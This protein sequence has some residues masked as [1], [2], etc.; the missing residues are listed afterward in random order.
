MKEKF[1]RSNSTWEKDGVAK[2]VG[3]IEKRIIH[4][5]VRR[6]KDV[7]NSVMNRV[8]TFFETSEY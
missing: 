4:K 7:F 2:P 8:G 1:R 3:K 6:M 5:K